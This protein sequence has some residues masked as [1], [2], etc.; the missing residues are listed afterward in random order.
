MAQESIREMAQRQSHRAHSVA[1][2][3]MNEVQDGEMFR[4]EHVPHL[5]WVKLAPEDYKV[6]ICLDTAASHGI[7][8]TL[9]G[10][11][12]R[13]A[14]QPLRLL[15]GHAQQGR[16]GRVRVGGAEHPAQRMDGVQALLHGE[17][18]RQCFDGALA[19]LSHSRMR[20][21]PTPLSGSP[22]SR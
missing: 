18:E 13:G 12:P 7:D 20:G 16:H 22:L 15:P 11:A 6:I 4:L 2:M 14:D 17:R 9:L 3:A 10:R 8:P 1:D 5:D 21:P 19:L